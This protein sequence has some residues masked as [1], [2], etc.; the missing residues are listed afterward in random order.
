MEELNAQ[1]KKLIRGLISFIDREMFEGDIENYLDD[2]DPNK[3]YDYDDPDSYN[4]EDY[5]I[6]DNV[7]DRNGTKIKAILRKLL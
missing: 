4:R 2:S 3:F 1:E 7:E 5:D 6:A